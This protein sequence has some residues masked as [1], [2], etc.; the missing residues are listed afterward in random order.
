[1]KSIEVTGKTIDEA[2]ESA[3]R[4]LETT[5]DKVKVDI[6]DE[7]NKGLF[8]FIGNKEA[9]VRVT[10]TEVSVEEQ[11]ETFVSEII[12]KMGVEATATVNYAEEFERY[13]IDIS[14][15]SVSALIGHRGEALDALQYIISLAVNK[16]REEYL[17]LSVDVEGYR[18]R[19]EETLKRLAEKNAARALKIRRNVSFD[20]MNPYERRIIH[21]ALQGRDNISTYST[22][23]EPNRRVV[24]AYKAGTKQTEE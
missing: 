10:I 4:Q 9:K 2:V 24:I 14:G 17:K 23:V 12:K 3:L 6:I 21:E 19:R 18:A 5:R 7:G 1:L 11:I 20:P 22:G 15:E 8:G 16:N 13:Q